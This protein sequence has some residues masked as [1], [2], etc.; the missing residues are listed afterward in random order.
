MTVKQLDGRARR[1]FESIRW[2]ADRCGYCVP[3]GRMACAKSLHDASELLDEARY[4]LRVAEIRWDP[5]DFIDD[6]GDEDEDTQRKLYN[7]ELTVEDCS[8]WIGEE[9]VASLGQIILGST[10]ADDNYRKIVE[11]ELAQEAKEA[12]REAIETELQSMT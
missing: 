1:R 10:Q 12:L 3:P 6:L 8:L 7:G 11:A 9:C 5:S 2:F 4:S